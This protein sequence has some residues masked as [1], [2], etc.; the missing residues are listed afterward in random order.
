VLERP[1]EPPMHA[2]QLQLLAHFGDHCLELFQK[3]L[4]IHPL[5]FDDILDQISDH[6]IFQIIQTINNY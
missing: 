4:R 6:L 2:P 3:K 5:I 1:A